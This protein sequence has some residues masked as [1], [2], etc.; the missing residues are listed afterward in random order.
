MASGPRRS[1]CRIL[2]DRQLLQLV[3]D[4]ETLNQ[5]QFILDEHCRA[6]PRYCTKQDCQST[7]Y[8]GRERC[9]YIQFSLHGQQRVSLH[10]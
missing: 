1:L 8:S 6:S 2:P 9:H 5:F 7:L 4:I 3:A 10:L